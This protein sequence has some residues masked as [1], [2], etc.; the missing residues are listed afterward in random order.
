MEDHVNKFML[1]LKILNVEHEDEVCRLFHFTF[2]GRASTWYFSLNLESINGWQDFQTA[3]L[4]KFGE[5]KTSAK[6]VLEL[7]RIK[8][9]PKEKVKDFNKR[10]LTLRNK[11]LLTSRPNN[12]VTVE[13]YT[14]TLPTTV[15][16]FV[17]RDEKITLNKKFEEAIKVEKYLL[18][19]HGKN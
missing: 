11:I 17:K 1:A 14:V 10:F 18:S 5:D 6:L 8:M 4:G 3:F 13:L 2:E 19:A 16:M 7:S 15:V 9:D 12:D